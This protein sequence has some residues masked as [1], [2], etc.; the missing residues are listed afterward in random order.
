MSDDFAHESSS[1]GS[2]TLLAAQLSILH[3][4]MEIVNSSIRQMDEITKDIKQWAIV[5]WT[6]AVGIALK[7]LHLRPFLGLTALIPLLFWVVDTS[8]RRVQRKMIFRM[9]QIRTFINTGLPEAVATKR[10]DFPL[11][12]PMAELGDRTARDHYMS[13]SY[14]MSFSTLAALYLG[15][16]FTSIIVAIVIALVS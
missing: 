15:L 1:G 13:W 4:E 7:E 11:L 10:I 14:V 12:D 2:D 3:D 16:I 6:A 8:F 9:R 5:A